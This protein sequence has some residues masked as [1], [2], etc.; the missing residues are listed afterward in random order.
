MKKTIFVLCMVFVI[1]MSIAATAFADAAI[2]DVEKADFSVIVKTPDGG[3]NMRYGPGTKYD[4]VMSGRIPDNVQL[5]IS[6]VSDNWGYTSYNGYEGWVALS[7]TVRVSE[8]EAK[9]PVKAGYTVYVKTP[10]G[11]VNMRTGPGTN[12]SIIV[13]I[14]D[15][16]ALYVE[17]T[18]DGWGH[19][20]YNGQYG[21]IA[22]SQTTTTA[23][24]QVETKPVETKPVETKP[25]ETKPT[26]PTEEVNQSPAPDTGNEPASVTPSQTVPMSNSAVTAENAMS[27]QFMLI[28]AVVLLIIVIAILL[29]VIIN[30]RS[31]K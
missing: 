11:G 29:I 15:G 20:N 12:N 3:L 31:R 16:V 1:V 8:K 28:A 21:W 25:D 13:K 5:Y 30:M 2:Y 18:L 22:L 4:K 17:E 23:P 10:D 14:A 26:T 24:A 9:T 19:I 6:A 7:Q 27:G